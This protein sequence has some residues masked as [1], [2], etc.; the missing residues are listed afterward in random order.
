MRSG[1]SVPRESVELLQKACPV[2]GCFACSFRCAEGARLSAPARARLGER[3]A[4]RIRQDACLLGR[5]CRSGPLGTCLDPRLTHAQ[6]S[7]PP[8]GSSV[9][10]GITRT[11]RSGGDV[12]TSP[13]I[14]PITPYTTAALDYRASWIAGEMM[15]K[16]KVRCSH[17]DAEK[18]ELQTKP[19]RRRVLICTPLAAPS[20]HRRPPVARTTTLRC[21]RRPTETRTAR[22]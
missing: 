13:G 20:S 16:T 7:A 14:N 12:G 3:R 8:Q 21:S 15:E 1:S 4:R 10:S 9:P 18:T 22:R 6:R 11:N 19:A 17:E 2:L 5:A